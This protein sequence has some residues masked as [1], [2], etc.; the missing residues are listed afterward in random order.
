LAEIRKNNKFDYQKK[1]NVTIP[2]GF[3]FDKR[4]KEKKISIR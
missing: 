2:V 3:G 4:D 1:F